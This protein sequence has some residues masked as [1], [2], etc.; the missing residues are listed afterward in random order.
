[1]KEKPEVDLLPGMRVEGETVFFDRS[2]TMEQAKR[3]LKDNGLRWVNFINIK[4]MEKEIR[5]WDV[6]FRVV[7]EENKAIVRG[8]AAVFN[9]LSENLGWFREQIEPGAF[10]EVMADD[11]RALF[12]HDPNYILG[13]TKP[14]TLR[15]SITDEGLVYEYDDPDTTYSRDL[16]K[17]MERGD[18]TQSS[19]AFYVGDDSWGKDEDGNDI[20]T[21]K[22]ISRLFDVS[23]V[24][25]P[26]YPDTS[27]GK[28]SFEAHKQEEAARLKAEKDLKELNEKITQIEINEAENLIG[29]KNT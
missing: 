27:V 25:Y 28:R 21:I 12:N 22:K 7:R 18:I 9:K 8:V 19:F 3:F 6:Q 13:R 16:L 4:E 11:V 15:L 14:G 29:H 20:R 1:M 5:I 24:T 2:W 26:A 10:D 23:P 17:S